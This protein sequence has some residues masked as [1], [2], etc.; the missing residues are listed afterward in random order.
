MAKIP[1]IEIHQGD[2]RL[3]V[4]AC[5]LSTWEAAGWRKAEALTPPTPQEPNTKPQK[6]SKH[7]Q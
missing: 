3:I 7:K 4:N 6:G 2:R 5:D 1:T